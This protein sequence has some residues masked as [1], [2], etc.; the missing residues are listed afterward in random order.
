MVFTHPRDIVFHPTLSF[1]EKRAILAS[2]AS[3]APAIASCPALRAPHGLR[4]HVHIDGILEAKPMRLRSVE[5]R[6][7]H[8]RLRSPRSPFRTRPSLMRSCSKPP[9]RQCQRSPPIHAESAPGS[10]SSPSSTPWG[11]A[12][13]RHPHVHCV[14]PGGGLSPDSARWIA[15]RPNFFLAVEPLARLFRRLFLER[16]TAAFDAGTLNFFGDLASLA[17]PA[18]FAAS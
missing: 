16:L 12:L 11:Q 6:A 8:C 7:S 1:A 3:D 15:S 17:K 9:P 13:T 18:A 10:A 4:A 5:R 14:V 2:W